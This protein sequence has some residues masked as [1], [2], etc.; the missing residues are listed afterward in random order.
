MVPVVLGHVVLVGA[1]GRIPRIW[2][3]RWAAGGTIG[4]LAYVGVADHMVLR[5][6]GG[7]RFTAGLPRQ[8]VEML[9]GG[10]R[11]AMALIA[12][13]LLAA[14]LPLRR[15]RETVFL[16]AFYLSS[17]LLIWLVVQPEFLYPRFFLWGVPAVA[18]AVAVAVRR[19]RA[20]AIVLVLAAVL[21]INAQIDHRYDIQAPVRLAGRVV[22]AATHEGERVC[23][24][25]VTRSPLI[26]ATRSFT[27]ARTAGE[28]D[29]CDLLVTLLP[30]ALPIIAVARER[31]RFASVLPAVTPGLVL[32]NER[33]PCRTDRVGAQTTI[34]SC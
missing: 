27:V 18:A 34:V 4:A 5:A 6:G 33:L 12:M 28:L 10:P 2:L 30:Q 32:S 9:L 24:D 1:R 21:Q 7:R 20:L 19:H 23:V 11:A 16:S 29:R 14:V 22:D 15:R 31:Y 26:V 13:L 8:V 3:G 17:F 25:T